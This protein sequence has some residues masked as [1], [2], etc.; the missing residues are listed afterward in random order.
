MMME[1]HK[2][3]ASIIREVN[4]GKLKELFSQKDFREACP[5]LG[6]GTYKAF[7]PKHRLGNPGGNSELFERVSK[8][9][10]KMVRPFKYGFD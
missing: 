1:R 7:L 6:E 10:F 4:G 2:V 5:N 3:Y 9:R 8:G